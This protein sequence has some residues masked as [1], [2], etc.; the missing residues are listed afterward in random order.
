MLRKELIFVNAKVFISSSHRTACEVVK[1]YK[2][3]RH[4]GRECILWVSENWSK[5]SSISYER[6]FVLR[7]E[8]RESF[9]EVI[10]VV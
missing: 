7:I 9:I 10:I 6:V 5:H 1:G 3:L 4:V 2:V 8:D